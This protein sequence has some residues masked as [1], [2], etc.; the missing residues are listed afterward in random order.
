MRNAI[1]LLLSLSVVLVSACSSLSPPAQA[2]S[3]TQPAIGDRIYLPILAANYTPLWIA[4]GTPNT[5]QGISQ[6]DGG[7]A[8]TE[9]I[10]GFEGGRRTGN[11]RS[12]PAA[13]GNNVPDFYMHFRVDDPI[14]W[15]GEPTSRV[16]I[17]VVYLDRGQDLFTIQYDAQSGGP[18]G[19]GRFKDGAFMAKSDTQ[20]YQTA[21]FSLCDAHF[22]NRNNGADF[23]IDDRGD[24][25]ETIRDVTLTLLEPL[26]SRKINVDSCGANPWD[27]EP[28]SEAIQACID[29]A[30]DGDTIT[31]TSGTDTPGYQG[32]VIDKTVFL[33]ATS[34]RR[35][36]IFTSTDPANRARLQA[37]AN[38]NGFLVRLYPRS[39]VV[40]PGS[41]DDI[42]ISHLVLDGGR[43]VRRC[44]GPDGISDGV[45]D[46]WGSWLPECPAVDDPWCKPGTLSMGGAMVWEDTTQNYL[47]TPALWGTGLVVDGVLVLNTEC[48]TAVHLDGAGGIIENSVIEGAGDHIHAPGC[49]PNDDDEAT[50]GWSDG[51][52]LAGPGHLVQNN[53][54][55]NPSDVGIVFF[56]GR[57]SRF[58]GNTVRVGAGN[59]GAFAGIAIHP[60][61]F[62]DV[63]GGVVTGNQILNEGD[64]ACGGIHAGI[65]I[66]QHMWGGG[67]FWGAHPSAVGN[68]NTCVLDPPPPS[69][70]WCE[71]GAMCQEWAHVAA[72]ESLTLTDNFVAGAQV[73]YLVEGLDLMGT[74]IES[75][76]TSG[77]PRMTDWETATAGCT[78]EGVTHSWAAIDRVAFHPTLDGWTAQRIHCER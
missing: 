28:D 11:G 59:Y 46:N 49:I 76:N 40:D 43:D 22:A 10:S 6:H 23:R 78:I 13:D 36:L 42:T 25:A 52:T 16:R 74:F 37:N 26:A 69:G 30:C 75:G 9:A 73:N 38:L 47:A 24:G 70:S 65:N 14:I 72:E 5:G 29:Q 20:Q 63:S 4:L 51:I 32:Y 71:G 35:N 8:D 7:D 31:F 64:S 48:G 61:I 57:N 34:A 56:G 45:G 39:R 27:S 33:V 18:L 60:W 62:G 50:G 41:I 54:I 2:D 15:A 53:T 44:F 68:A 21:V 3:P 66:G 1:A 17:D 12:L 77:S 55:L 19:D 67:C 58:I